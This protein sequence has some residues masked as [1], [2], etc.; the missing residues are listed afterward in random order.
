MTNPPNS[1]ETSRKLNILLTEDNMLNRVLAQKLLQ[2]FR[3]PRDSGEQ[4]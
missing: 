4:R 2:K 3:S 1:A